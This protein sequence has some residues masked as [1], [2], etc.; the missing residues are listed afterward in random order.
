MQVWYSHPRFLCHADGCGSGSGKAR[1]RGNGK[2]QMAP[3][4]AAV[5]V[6]NVILP[7]V[8]CLPH[9]CSAQRHHKCDELSRVC[10]EDRGI[11]SGFRP[12]GVQPPQCSV[13]GQQCCTLPSESAL[14]ALQPSISSFSSVSASPPLSIQESTS[15]SP[16]NLLGSC[17]QILERQETSRLT[18]GMP[19][20]TIEAWREG[21]PQSHAIRLT[22]RPSC[23]VFAACV[24]RGF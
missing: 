18:P 10:D 24:A 11:Y 14:C 12:Y 8:V 22:S 5:W 20:K 7:S 2:R 9:A 19:D 16:T 21:M 3:L 6:V 17:R 15:N 4:L 23:P 1:R 13:G